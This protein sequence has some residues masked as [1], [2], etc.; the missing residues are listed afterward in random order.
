MQPLEDC[1]IWGNPNP[2]VGT[3]DAASGTI[4]VTKSH[5]AG[6][7]FIIQDSRV[8]DSINELDIDQ[9]CRL[10]TWLGNCRAQGVDCPIITE[11]SI[12]HIRTVR[13]LGVQERADRL[14][15]HLAEQTPKLG[16]Q[17]QITAHSPKIFAICESTDFEEVIVL[18]RHLIRQG[19]VED[20][21]GFN[22]PWFTGTVTFAGR[23]TLDTR[24]KNVASAQA[25]VAMWINEEVDA[26]FEN[27]LKSAIRDAGYVPLRIDKKPD[28]N[29]LDDEI[30][31]EIR[32]SRF[33][34]ADFTQ[35]SDGARGSVYF[36]TG[37]AYGIG[38]P[39]IHTCR[40]DCFDEIHFDTQ[41]YMH[42]V[43][44]T[45]QDLRARLASS[46]VARVGIG[47]FPA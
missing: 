23:S 2:A 46:I 33:L 3:R 7:G 39:V 10:T 30:I 27:G 36:E 43:W 25:F 14:L 41:Q 42:I 20:L 34:V 26:A 1:P 32:R 15:A 16:S 31:A 8:F 38:I 19:Y 45:D 24:E 5:R 40:F 28:A 22:N 37:F 12:A 35:G 9:K 18:M 17:F 11:D 44:K 4:T 6:G 13:P 21:D 29:K 47:P